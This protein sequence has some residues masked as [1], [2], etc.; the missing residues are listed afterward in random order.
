MRNIIEDIQIRP[1]RPDAI[2]ENLSGG[3][4]QKI[5]VGK[6]LL[7]NPKMVIFDE[8]TRGI[9][10]GA[11]AEIYQRIRELTRRGMGV[12]MASSELPELIGMCDRILVFHEG[13]VVGELQRQDFSEE[14]IMQL[15]TASN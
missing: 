13:R 7:T 12:I 14:A 1:S 9:D 4:Q 8:P 15:A 11:K 5:V 6:W 10:V 3:N 2:A